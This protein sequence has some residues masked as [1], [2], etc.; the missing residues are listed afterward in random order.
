MSD[1]APTTGAS[2]RWDI[3]RWAIGLLIAALLL[4]VP[5]ATNEYTQYVVNSIVVYALVGLGF[6]IV[7]GYLGQLAFANAAL[8]GIGAYTSGI[9]MTKVGFPYELAILSSAAVG[10]VAGAL[11]GLPALR[12]KGYYLAIVTLAFGELL[13]WAYIHADFLTDGSSGLPVG[14]PSVLGYTLTTDVER[15]YLILAVTA[16]MFWLTRNILA[17]KVGRA[18]VAIRENE[19]AGQALGLAPAYVKITAFAW[20]GLLVGVAGSLFAI[21]LGRIAPENFG[22]HQ[23]LVHFSIVMIGGLGSLLG[24]VLG[25][26]LL[27]AAPELLRNFAGL[28]EIVFSLLLIGVLLFMPRGLAGL[29]V[30][31]VPQWRERLYRGG[32]R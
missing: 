5:V 30:T 1:L 29:V 20:S 22:L 18:F 9:L 3:S 6:N 31:Y 21:L 16:F 15:Y 7:I 23:L 17:S 28:E 11:V 4:A 24:S 8:F 14:E 10:F 13:R 32:P 12:L 27:T 25:A 2:R 19:L 26:T